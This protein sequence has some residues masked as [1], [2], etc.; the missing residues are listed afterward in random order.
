MKIISTNIAEEREIEWRGKLVK[1]GIFKTEVKQPLYLDFTD[2]KNDNVVDRKYHGGLNKACYLY[3]ADNYEYWQKKYPSL[4]FSWGMFGEN[5]TISGLNESNIY[6]GQE[7][8]IGKAVIQVSQPR[9]PC[10]KLGFRFGNQSVVEEFWNSPIPGVYVRV[11]KPGYVQ[12]GDVL[13]PVSETRNDLSI[14]QV[15]SVFSDYENKKEIAQ[16]A[17]NYQLLAESCRVDIQKIIDINKE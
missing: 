16:K 1:T 3:S 13:I 5:L 10:F 9:Q 11:L 7:Y 6:I 4:E 12:T 14:S 17:V 8:Q 2:V 15:F